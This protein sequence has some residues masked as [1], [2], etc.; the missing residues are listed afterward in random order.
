M[1]ASKLTLLNLPQEI[2]LLILETYFASLTVGIRTCR[3]T[4]KPP[5]LFHR[6]LYFRSRIHHLTHLPLSL[7][8]LLSCRPLYKVAIKIM[9]EATTIRHSYT[10]WI[11]QKNSTD[12][13]ISFHKFKHIE[14]YEPRL[15]AE[16][17]HPWSWPN[18]R[19]MKV[20][21]SF[22]ENEFHIGRKS[23]HNL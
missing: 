20:T 8:I 5:R 21:K 23:F 2:L 19:A 10:L 1:S 15:A 14:L 6:L 7:S 3:D 18:L 4:R 13:W 12:K 9:L 22:M 11:T 17:L 16:C